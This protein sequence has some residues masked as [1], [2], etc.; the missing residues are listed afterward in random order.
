M[1]T[2]FQVQLILSHDSLGKK[3]ELDVKRLEI[4]ENEKSSTLRPSNNL[5]QYLKRFC[6]VINILSYN[7]IRIK[8]QKTLIEFVNLR[9]FSAINTFSVAIL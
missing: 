6:K 9:L 2:T 7:L 5:N 4:V 3:I 1:F 8:N